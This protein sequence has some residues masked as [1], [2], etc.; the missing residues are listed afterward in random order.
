MTVAKASGGTSVGR[1][2]SSRCVRI[3]GAA[4][5]GDA[6][7]CHETAVLGQEPSA[8]PAGG[9]AGQQCHQPAVPGDAQRD[10]NQ[11]AFPS[12]LQPREWDAGQGDGG[13]HPVIRLVR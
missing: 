9:V 12:L 1:K 10:K 5:L 4:G 6:P 2:V 13:Y 7:D 3:V 8:R 11:R